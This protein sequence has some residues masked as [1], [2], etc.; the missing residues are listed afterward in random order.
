MCEVVEVKRQ[1]ADEGQMME[2]VEKNIFSVQSNIYCTS[3]LIE[4]SEFE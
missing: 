2:E 4:K 3:P 1:R